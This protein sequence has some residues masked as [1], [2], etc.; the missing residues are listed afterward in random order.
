M[1]VSVIVPA[2][3]EEK[4]IVQGLTD[5]IKTLDFLEIDYE[6]IIVVD[7]DP[8]TWLIARTLEHPKVEFLTY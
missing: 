4:N 8:N 6:I 3:H 1:K 7:G 2:Y 5:L